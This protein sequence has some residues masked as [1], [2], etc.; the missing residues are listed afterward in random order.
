MK[1]REIYDVE[2][3]RPFLADTVEALDFSSQ[4]NEC[5]EV[6]SYPVVLDASYSFE[7]ARGE[8]I[9]GLARICGGGDNFGPG[10][11]ST[12]ACYEYN[13]ENNVWRD[14]E[15]MLQARSGFGSSKLTT[16]QWLVTGG[17]L[18]NE[19]D[20]DTSEVWVDGEWIP[21]PTLLRPTAFHCQV[22]LNTTHVFIAGGGDY[23]ND[24]LS[25]DAYILNTEDWSWQ[26]LPS[27]SLAR[28]WGA[29]GYVISDQNGQEVVVGSGSD[30]SN[31]VGIFS[32]RDLEWRDGPPLDIGA[33]SVSLQM[34]DNFLV[35]DSLGRIY[36]FDASSYLW[37]LS[38]ITLD[39]GR[40]YPAVVA[41]PDEAVNC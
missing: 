16:N 3:C 30:S 28:G 10:E 14:V 34:L 29:C 27:M 8:L 9:N 24:W 19:T 33:G 26:I 20:L 5:D 2:Q 22:S 15:P 12:N 4:T 38:S 6:A 13:P 17:N 18:N 31:P 37:V 36:E 21:G 32:L 1:C 23:T 39:V 41:V 35:F 25:T 7:S 11:A 40:G